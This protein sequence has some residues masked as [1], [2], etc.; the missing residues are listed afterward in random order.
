MEIYKRHIREIETI[1][2]YSTDIE[3]YV[4]ILIAFFFFFLPTLIFE[5][6]YGRWL[7]G[8]DLLAQFTNLDLIKQPSIRRLNPP[9]SIHFDCY[10]LYSQG[11][12]K[13][14]YLF[15]ATKAKEGH[16]GW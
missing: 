15:A 11:T 6:F 13:G 12:Q 3:S 1:D 10:S 16:N 4:T 7:Q 8:G 5:N 2:F 9:L 14:E